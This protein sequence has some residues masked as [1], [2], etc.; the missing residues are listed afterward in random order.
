LWNKHSARF[1]NKMAATAAAAAA[2]RSRGGDEITNVDGGLAR[3]CP[4]PLKR[5]DDRP[6][7][8][9]GTSDT[10][11]YAT[12]ARN[13]PTDAKTRSDRDVTTRRRR[14]QQRE[15]SGDSNVVT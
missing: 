14:D 15:L 11:L 1:E 7:V 13:A 3:D 6:L 5:H 10:R 2:I 12:F 9:L 4:A 8:T